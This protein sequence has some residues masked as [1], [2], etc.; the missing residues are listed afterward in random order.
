MPLDWFYL[1][2]QNF[3]NLTPELQ[4]SVYRS[5]YNLVYQDITYLLGGDR[6]LTEDII[7]ESFIKT[8]SNVDQHKITN[9]KAWLRQVTRNYTLDYLKKIKK[10]R[11]ATDIA[12][13]FEDNTALAVQQISVALEVEEKIRDELL[14]K[15][16]SELKQDYRT[17]ITLFYIEEMSYKEMAK[18]LGLSEQAI[19]QKL[20]RARKKLLHQFQRK[21][22]EFNE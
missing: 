20:A 5:F 6:V 8:I 22:A 14:R 7:Q 3:K 19:S 4:K 17:V 21:W 13:I 18:L 16:I 9:S 11:Q 1:F 10:D 12:K 2:H 15:T